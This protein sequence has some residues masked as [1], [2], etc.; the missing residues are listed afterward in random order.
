MRFTL[1]T[2]LLAT[3]LAAPLAMAEKDQRPWKV[4]AE[5]GAIATSGNTETTTIQ[6]KIDAEHNTPN[7]S[8]R[9]TLGVL[10]KEDQIQQA[11]GSTATVKTA[12]R[13]SVSARGGYRLA[14]E[15]STLFVYG[16]HV[17]DE[18]A[19]YSTYTTVSVGYGARLHDGSR[20]QLDAEIGPG[21]YWADQ[22]LSDGSTVA[23]SSVIARGA[24]KFDWQWTESADFRQ[25]LSVETGPDNTR[26]TSDTS[27]ST[28]IN[29]AFQMK[30]G[31]NLTS[32]TDVAPGKERTDTTTYVNLVYSF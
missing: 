18:F 19:A 28:R 23:E 29:N 8:N 20:T 9:Y 13:V 26:T 21:Y 4:S 31:F 17:D 16:S 7:W 12:E 22:R 10:F 11:D 3:S 30:V 27:L 32:D 2:T 24:L 1:L 6:G 5:V 25:V 15:H 14:R